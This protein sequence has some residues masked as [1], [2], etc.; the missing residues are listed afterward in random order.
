MDSVI[1]WSVNVVGELKQ[2]YIF[3]LITSVLKWD[4]RHLKVIIHNYIHFPNMSFIRHYGEPLL[5][6]GTFSHLF[7]LTTEVTY[8]SF[9]INLFNF[10]RLLLLLPS[11][12]HFTKKRRWKILLVRLEH[13]RKIGIFILRLSTLQ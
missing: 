13:F 9:S 6:E 7:V 8:T 3:M 12:W 2:F 10:Q 11:Y 5:F 4:H 1:F